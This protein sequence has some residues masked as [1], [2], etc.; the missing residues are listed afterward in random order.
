VSPGRSETPNRCWTSRG[1]RKCP[2]DPRQLIEESAFFIAADSD[3]L[4]LGVTCN[5]DEVALGRSYV[6]SDPIGLRAG[7]NTYAY[8]NSVPLGLADPD[9]L[10]AI[11]VPAPPPEI[12]VPWW[13]PLAPIIGILPMLTGDT[14]Q[15]DGCCKPCKT[16]SG[17]IVP[18][19]TIGYRL[20]VVPPG[21]PHYPFPGD[22]YNLYEANQIP[23][24]N[25]DCFWQVA[26]AADAANGAPPPAGSIPVE[27]FNNSR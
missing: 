12:A 11:T 10:A 8:V 27:P 21:R 20:D 25:C 5:Y 4:G 9:G 14:Q 15:K 1:R 18:I 26:G 7:V 2:L 22:H 17:R 16:I 24:P 19:G 13:G 23:Y 6:Q 3:V